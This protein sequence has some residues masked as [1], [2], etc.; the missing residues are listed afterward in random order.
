MMIA[1]N[2]SGHPRPSNPGRGQSWAREKR[3]ILIF[4]RGYRTTKLVRS[5]CRTGRDTPVK[6]GAIRRS[7]SF[8]CLFPE[9][10]DRCLGCCPPKNRVALAAT[11]LQ[12]LLD[13]KPSF[14]RDGVTAKKHHAK[15]VNYLQRKAEKGKERRRSWH[16]TEDNTFYT[17][18][19]YLAATDAVFVNYPRSSLHPS[20]S[21]IYTWNVASDVPDCAFDHGQLA[22]SF[23]IYIYISS[24][25]R[26]TIYRFMIPSQCFSLIEIYKAIKKTGHFLDIV[27]SGQWNRNEETRR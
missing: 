20:N 17:P 11:L 26:R 10:R 14:G 15:I 16:S 2:I 18:A 8:P 1:T 9:Q 6:R 27:L 12:V 23:I 3:S 24:K 13:Q 21:F 7:F 5:E 19:E 22:I 4:W 25:K